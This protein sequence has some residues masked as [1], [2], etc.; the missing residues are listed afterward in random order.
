MCG[1]N[2]DAGIS[3][4]KGRDKRP[5]FDRLLKDATSRKVNM[6][7]AWSVAHNA[8]AQYIADAVIEGA[9]ALEHIARLLQAHARLQQASLFAAYS[10]VF[11]FRSAPCRFLIAITPFSRMMWL[12]LFW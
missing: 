10:F 1:C 8:G 4:A 9:A 2:E 5:G 7:A 6:I 12:A 11:A 3:G